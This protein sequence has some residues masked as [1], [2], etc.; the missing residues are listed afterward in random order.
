VSKE[1]KV[2]ILTVVG[3]LVF[4]FG[5]KYLSGSKI[6]KKEN[7]YYAVY[8]SVEGL[9]PSNPVS[10]N[11]YQVG[12]VA[13]IDLIITGVGTS[14]ALVTYAINDD[15]DIPKGSSAMIYQADL[16]GE[17]S[18][19]FVLLPN[20]QNYQDGDTIASSTQLGMVDKLAASITPLI[21]HIDSLV[22]GLNSLVD[23]NNKDNL[24][25]IIHNLNEVTAGLPKIA[26]GIDGLVNDKSSS[27]NQ[28]LGNLESFTVNLNQNNKQ[29]NKVIG[30][31]ANFTDTLNQTELKATILSAKMALDQV[32]DLLD[33]VNNGDGTLTHLVKDKKLYDNL[34]LASNNLNLLLE[35]FKANPNRYVHLSLLKIDRTVKTEK[36]AKDQKKAST[37]PAK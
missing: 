24:Q 31:L 34:Q 5:Y 16:L 4:V 8:E 2:G 14:K 3:I 30:N 25:A 29:I 7:T 19:K 22:V 28:T 36:L 11:G 37:S 35:D 23:K 21:G 13:S 6:F 26:N 12:R 20:T 33:K 18:V 1:I 32:N 17:K 15:I 27:L 9:F 10:I